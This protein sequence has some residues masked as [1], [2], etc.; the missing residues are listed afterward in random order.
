MNYRLYRYETNVLAP[1]IMAGEWV[2]QKKSRQ[3]F[4]RNVTNGFKTEGEAQA[5]MERMR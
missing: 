1:D 3:G 5:A 2:V 4:W